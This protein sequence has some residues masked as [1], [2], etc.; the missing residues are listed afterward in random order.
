VILTVDE[1]REMTD[2]TDYATDRFLPQDIVIVRYLSEEAT[3][4]SLALIREVRG[5]R[6]TVAFFEPQPITVCS[7]LNFVYLM[8]CFF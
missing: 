1:V 2:F 5:W 6:V 8:L 3:A 7:C 4:Y